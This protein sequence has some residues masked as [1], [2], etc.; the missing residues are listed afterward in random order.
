MVHVVITGPSVLPITILHI[1]GTD[2]D[3]LPEFAEN[4]YGIN[5]GLGVAGEAHA[6]PHT[7]TRTFSPITIRRH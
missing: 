7:P 6:A 4:I 2:L 3:H 1:E 5:D